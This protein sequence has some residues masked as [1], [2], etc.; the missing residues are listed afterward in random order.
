LKEVNE[1]LIVH[2]GQ[3]LST[4]TRGPFLVCQKT[5][6]QDLWG[7][8]DKSRVSFL[9]QVATMAIAKSASIF[10][11]LKDCAAE[12]LLELKTD[13]V[14]FDFAKI[15]P[16]AVARQIGNE[17]MTKLLV[18][19]IFHPLLSYFEEKSDSAI[20]TK[21]LPFLVPSEKI[22]NLIAFNDETGSPSKEVIWEKFLEDV[23]RVANEEKATAYVEHGPRHFFSKPSIHVAE[24]NAFLLMIGH[25][26]KSTKARRGENSL[27][28]VFFFSPLSWLSCLFFCLVTSLAHWWRRLNRGN[29]GSVGDW[30]HEPSQRSCH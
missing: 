27:L 1:G 14:C 6:A 4:A 28:L 19:T 5:A 29:I 16:E 18:E 13:Q 2:F 9:D 24:M 30:M 26:F 17:K 11:T 20:P 15:E 22:E 10:P 25:E 12:T 7:R 3:A 21:L 8:L 23:K